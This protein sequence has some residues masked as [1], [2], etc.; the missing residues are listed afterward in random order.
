MA[1]IY[2]KG[3]GGRRWRGKRRRYWGEVKKRR[4]KR[5]D[6]AVAI[7][8]LTGIS[9]SPIMVDLNHVSGSGR[10]HWLERREDYRCKGR[11]KTQGDSLFAVYA[12]I[13]A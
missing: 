5:E 10:W 3:G 8:R 4:E 13:F 12:H 1:L 9:F 7:Y 2:E 6:D 11:S